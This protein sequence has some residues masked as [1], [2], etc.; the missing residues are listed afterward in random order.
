MAAHLKREKELWQAGFSAVCGVDEVGR[1]PLAGPVVACACIL[2]KDAK[3][4]G[5]KDSKLLTPELRQSIAKRLTTHAGVIWAIGACCHETIDA[6][7]IFQATLQ[8]MQKAIAALRLP[9]DYIL[10]DGTHCPASDIPSESIVKGD[11]TCQSIAAASIIAK[12]HRDALMHE[13]HKIYPQYGF[14]SHKGYSTVA[15]K[16]AIRNHGLCPI[17]RK[18]FTVIN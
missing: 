7:N 8:A 1:G 16:E 6:I 17:H 18:T 12:V 11:M 2:P 5:I 9:P 4:R 13:Y 10:V 3:F 15:H 14:D